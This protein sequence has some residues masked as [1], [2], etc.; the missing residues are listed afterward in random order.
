MPGP[1]RAPI[2]P[3]RKR[4]LHPLHDRWKLH[5]VLRLDVERQPLFL[6]PEPPKLEGEELPRLAKRSTE[7]RYR[8]PSPKQRLT[9]VDRCPHFIPSILNQKPIFSHMNINMGLTRRFASIGQKKSDKK[10][11]KV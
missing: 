3:H 11:G 7:D 6:K 9:I 1:L 8:L 2:E 5:P 10:Q 4:L